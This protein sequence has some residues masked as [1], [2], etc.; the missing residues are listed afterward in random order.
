MK[1]NHLVNQLLGEEEPA[2]PVPA[3]AVPA[4][5]PEAKLKVYKAVKS[6]D[7]ELSDTFH[8]Y[9]G[10]ASND[11][12]TISVGDLEYISDHQ[13]TFQAEIK[14][15]LAQLEAAGADLIILT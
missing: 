13:E 7:L 2:A 9:L 14:G 3:A 4:P 8:E 11:G 1:P 15:I 6:D 12:S 10:E 5:A